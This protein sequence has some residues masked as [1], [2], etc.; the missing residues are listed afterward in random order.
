MRP[1]PQFSG[2]RELRA[3]QFGY[4]VQ[5]LRGDTCS[6]T[7]KMRIRGSRRHLFDRNLSAVGVDA[8]Q[9]FSFDLAPDIDAAPL[10]QRHGDKGRLDIPMLEHAGC[11]VLI[12]ILV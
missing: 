6:A 3:P 4:A 5:N 2:A 11:I 1:F 7:N 12:R 10:G 9:L 8:D